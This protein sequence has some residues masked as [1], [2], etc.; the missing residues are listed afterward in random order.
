MISRRDKMS[1]R[2]RLVMSVSLPAV[3][4]FISAYPVA[5]AKPAA[6]PS[7]CRRLVGQMRLSPERVL[8]SVASPER[9]LRPWVVFAQSDSAV[10]TDAYSRVASIWQARMPQTMM[11][12][13]EAL[14]RSDLFMAYGVVGAA[15]CLNAVFVEWKHRGLLHVVHAPPISASQCGRLDSWG[16]LATVLGHS[17]YLATEPLFKVTN[18]GWLLLIA[19][20]SGAKWGHP[21]YVAVRFSRQYP[22]KLQYCGSD[23]EVCSAAKKLAPA[24]DRQ[25]HAYSREQLRAFNEGSPIIPP[26]SIGNALNPLSAQ[27]RVL[28]DRARRLAIAMVPKAERGSVPAWLVHGISFF[29]LQLEDKRYL[30]AAIEALRPFSIAHWILPNN[31]PYLGAL[32]RESSPGSLFLVYPVP[33]AGSER[34]VPIAVFTMHWRTSGLHSIRTLEWPPLGS[35]STITFDRDY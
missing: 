7:L 35:G 3:A 5:A 4:A 22:V 11:A 16:G 18:K 27:D 15:D 20:W 1:G 26:F 2:A 32:K 17:A 14:P 8:Q 6:T 33:R 9:W 12:G 30:G 19:T 10:G 13:I 29:P 28:V 31:A 25:Y 23:P 34:L 21:C 24:V